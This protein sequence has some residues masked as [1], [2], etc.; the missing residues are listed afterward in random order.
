MCAVCAK[1]LRRAVPV[2]QMY[3][4]IVGSNNANLISNLVMFFHLPPHLRPTFDELIL[5]SMEKSSTISVQFRC[6]RLSPSP[7]HSSSFIIWWKLFSKRRNCLITTQS[8]VSMHPMGWL[9]Q[10]QVFRGKKK[11]RVKRIITTTNFLRFSQKKTKNNRKLTIKNFLEER[12]KVVCY[13][14]IVLMSSFGIP[15]DEKI[16]KSE[17]QIQSVFHFVIRLVHLNQRMRLWKGYRKWQNWNL[18]SQPSDACARKR[19][20]YLFGFRCNYLY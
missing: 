9:S 2:L 16:K 6:T 14:F 7:L 18:C 1:R 17:W 19:H 8:D 15:K 12:K 3:V 4:N 5:S 10:L 11:G 20:C 13:L